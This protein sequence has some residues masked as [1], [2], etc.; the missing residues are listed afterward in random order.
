MPLWR[1]LAARIQAAL[2]LATQDALRFHKRVGNPI[3]VWR[4][5]KPVWIPPEEIPVDLDEAQAPPSGMQA[6]GCPIASHSS[7]FSASSTSS[8]ATAAVLMWPATARPSRR[9]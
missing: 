7:S 1:A 6:A 2:R 4:E 3:V 5:G 8:L 9:R